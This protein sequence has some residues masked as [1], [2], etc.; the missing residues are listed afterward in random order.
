MTTNGKIGINMKALNKWLLQI[1]GTIEVIIGAAHFGMP[2]FAFQLPGFSQLNPEASNFVSLCILA[3]GLLLVAIGLITVLVA[4]TLAASNR[5][6]L[7]FLVIKASL[8]SG[9]IVLEILYPVS[10]PLFFIKNPS[11]AVLT[12]LMAN[13]L[14]IVSSGIITFITVTKGGSPLEESIRI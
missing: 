4:S 6:L 8:W 7:V 1:A 3:V 13:W 10:I 9:R 2:Y 5:A 14:L 12:I 11:T